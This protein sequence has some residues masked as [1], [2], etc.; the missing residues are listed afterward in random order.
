MAVLGT[1]FASCFGRIPRPRP[2]D[3]TDGAAVETTGVDVPLNRP[4]PDEI[5]E[6]DAIEATGVAVPLSKEGCG[7]ATV[8]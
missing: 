2:I 6:G 1:A 4:R 5:P 7:V 3:T 8:D